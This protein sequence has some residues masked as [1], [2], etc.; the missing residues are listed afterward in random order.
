MLKKHLVV[1][2]MSVLLCSFIFAQEE[3]KEEKPPLGWNQEVVGNLSFNQSKFDNWQRGGEDSW[4]WQLDINGLVEYQQEKYGWVN[5]GKFAYGN[6]KTGGS[7]ARKSADEIRLESVL[8]YKATQ[9]LNPYVSV[10]GQTQFVEGYLY[11]DTS[12]IRISNFMDPGY[13][14]QAIGIGFSPSKIFST[15]FGASIKETITR[16]DQAKNLF[17]SGES[18]RVEY[19]AE[20]VSDL[21]YQVAENILYTSRLEMFSTLD[22]INEVDVNWDNLFTAKVAKYINVTFNFNL[23]YDRDI[24][25]QRQIKQ[26]LA[27]GL[28]YTFL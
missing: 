5:K 8:F 11:T 15:R 19:G 4:N 12:K 28:T 26:T 2:F 7:E 27:V 20:S 23:F 16:T 25:D 13:F 1:I 24:S 10:S 22:A 18:P 14:T 9:Y 17:A 3:K 21:N 6:S